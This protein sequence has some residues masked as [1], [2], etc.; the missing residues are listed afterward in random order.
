MSLSKSFN[1]PF[2]ELRSLPVHV[3][4]GMYNIAGKMA[5]EEKKASKEESEDA[6]NSISM[7]SMPRVPSM[8][9]MPSMPRLPH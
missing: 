8:P 7:P 3:V 1:Q 6:R 5:E 4:I 9:S 2:S